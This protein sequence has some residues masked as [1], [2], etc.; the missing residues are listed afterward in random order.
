MISTTEHLS[1]PAATNRQVALAW[2]FVERQT[3][4]W[5]RYWAWEIVWLV[6]GGGRPAFRQLQH[7][8]TGDLGRGAAAAVPRARHPDVVHG[9]GA[10]AAGIRR[11]LPG[12]G[13]SSVAARLFVRLAGDLYP[14]RH[15]GRSDRRK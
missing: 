10:R 12:R 1:L 7:R 8:R 14:R 15:P 4:L 6:Y 9:A 13:A 2:A 5:K 3:N 11:V